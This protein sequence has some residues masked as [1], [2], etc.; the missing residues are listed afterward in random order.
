MRNDSGMWDEQCLRL[1]L[2]QCGKVARLRKHNRI[3]IDR[4][5]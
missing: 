5:G 3:S 2:V 4:W 1:H